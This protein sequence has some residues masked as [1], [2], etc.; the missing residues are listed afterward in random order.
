[1]PCGKAVDLLLIDV[2]RAGF[3]NLT[4]SPIAAKFPYCSHGSHF[5]G[6]YAFRFL[7]S[8]GN[9]PLSVVGAFSASRRRRCRH[10]PFRSWSIPPRAAE[11]SQGG[12][13]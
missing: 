13:P 5:H 11:G 1:M 12:F 6:P 3:R 9:S 8:A 4:A 7:R 2:F 10:D